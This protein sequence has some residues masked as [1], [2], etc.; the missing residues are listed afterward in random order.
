MSPRGRSSTE[1]L[2]RQLGGGRGPWPTAT[3]GQRI[4]GGCWYLG[5]CVA[6]D[7]VQPGWQRIRSFCELRS[8]QWKISSGVLPHTPK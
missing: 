8:K 5:L 3:H 2:G 1:Q 4:L 6:W 7:E